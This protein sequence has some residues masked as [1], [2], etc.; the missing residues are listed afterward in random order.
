MKKKKKKD[1]ISKS[2]FKIYSLKIKYKKVFLKE[3]IKS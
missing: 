1:I 2:T 3:S